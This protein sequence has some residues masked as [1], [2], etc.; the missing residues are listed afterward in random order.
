[1]LCVLAPEDVFMSPDPLVRDLLDATGYNLARQRDDMWVAIHQDTGRR[2]KGSTPEAVA[3]SALRSLR[4]QL[5]DAQRPLVAPNSLYADISEAQ[6]ELAQLEAERREARA[7]LT[8]LRAE[9]RR[10]F[11]WIKLLTEG[12]EP[13]NGS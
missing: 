13:S 9:M 10:P 3:R 7:E 5:V 4:K 2:V 1:M 12:D 8:R 6:A 11:R